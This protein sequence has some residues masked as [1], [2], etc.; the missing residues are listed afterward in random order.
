MTELIKQMSQYDEMEIVNIANHDSS[1][2][3]LKLAETDHLPQIEGSRLIYELPLLQDRE[4][5][6]YAHYEVKA[7]S[8]LAFIRA[9]HNSKVEYIHE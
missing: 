3:D 5:K 9:I 6:R 2:I 4:K 7:S 1:P 8:M